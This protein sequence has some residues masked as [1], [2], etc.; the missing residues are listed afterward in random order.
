MVHLYT[1]S[2]QVI[3]LLLKQQIMVLNLLIDSFELF[4]KVGCSH[5][6]QPFY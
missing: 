1:G 6:E 4:L 5:L 3:L 2:E